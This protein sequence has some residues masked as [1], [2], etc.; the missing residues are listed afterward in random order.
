MN[1]DLCRDHRFPAAFCE[2]SVNNTFSTDSRYIVASTQDLFQGFSQ[3]IL[4]DLSENLAVRGLDLDISEM[5][6]LIKEESENREFLESHCELH[7]EY[8]TGTSFI[9]EFDIS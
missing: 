9:C 3:D 5:M 4:S 1:N 6:V 7:R 8:S 2:H